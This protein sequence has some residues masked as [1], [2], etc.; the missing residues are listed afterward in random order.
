MSD[1]REILRHQTPRHFRKIGVVTILIALCVVVY[2]VTSRNRDDRALAGE[3]VD[4]A[5]PAVKV[6]RLS[7]FTGDRTLVLPGNLEAFNSA[8]IHA[9]V[10][11]YLKQWYVD[12]GTPVRN[13]QLLAEI[14]VP[15]LDQQLMQAKADLATAQANEQLADST[16][17]RWHGLLSAD[18]V[19]RQEDDEK[20]GD[21]AAK[22]AQVNAARANVSRLAALETFKRITAPFDG[23]VTT[24]STDIGALIAVGGPSDVPLFTVA[25]ERKL[26]VYVAVPQG[27]S[28]RIH[29]G[30]KASFSVPQHPGRNFEAEVT[31]TAEAIDMRNGTL[32][33]QLQTDNSQRALHPGDYAQIQFDLGD[34]SAVAVPAS[35][36]V[37]RESGMAVATIGADNRVV[38]KP[39]TISRDF[40]PAVE[41]TSGLKAMDQI[42]DNPPDLLRQGD[43]VHVT[44]DAAQGSGART[45]AKS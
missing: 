15:D 27:Y 39:I 20:R 37:F 25:D 36:L 8:P 1:E 10:S 6:I 13:G 17:A 11:G 42:I 28:A 41:V 29:A 19:S 30:M 43:V 7:A 21:Q 23:I 45:H 5:V 34:S 22:H 38:F 26:R 32:R 4:A 16:A 44:A 40:G 3:S 31:T 35:A 9:R 33:V 14:D 2:G 12:I 18:A 24:R